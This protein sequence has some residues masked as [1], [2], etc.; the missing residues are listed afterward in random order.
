MAVLFDSVRNHARTMEFASPSVVALESVL[1]RLYLES[2]LAGMPQGVG[3]SGLGVPSSGL[4]LHMGPP[5]Q[6]QSGGH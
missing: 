6:H 5:D 4:G 1:I 2:P 3:G